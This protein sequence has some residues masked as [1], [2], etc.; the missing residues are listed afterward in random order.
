MSKKGKEKDNDMR[1]IKKEYK[2]YVIGYFFV[3]LIINFIIIA[4][5]CN[6]ISIDTMN[7]IKENDHIIKPIYTLIGIP[8][9]SVIGL[10]ILNVIPSNMKEILIF[11]KIKN[12]LP[13]YRWQ[14]K[15][16]YKDSRIN[17]KLLNRK[18]GKNLNAQKQHDI[19]YKLYQKYKGDEVILESQKDYLFAR[20]LCITTI[21]ILTIIIVIY[22]IGKISI[23]L[24][25]QFIIFNIAIL[26]FLYI[27][28]NIVSKNNANRFICNVLLL[29][30]NTEK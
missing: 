22:L 17:I 27:I 10:L 24:D 15:I 1:N 8:V 6:W 3:Y 7:I 30:I 28:L 16:A 26:L 2:K 5:K 23:N 19:W 29:D 13:S 14:D 11:W 9:V 18:Y 4:I 25:M 21:L 12:R 20:D